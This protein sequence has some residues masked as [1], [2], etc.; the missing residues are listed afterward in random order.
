MC[1]RS[2][3]EEPS[4][5]QSCEE[6]PDR[7]EGEAVREVAMPAKGDERVAGGA[8]KDI[9]IRAFAGEQAREGGGGKG[10]AGTADGDTSGDAE[11]GVRD[12]IHALNL[13]ASVAEG[14]R[15]F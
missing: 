2:A 5:D 8:D 10:G 3:A 13:R 11:G 1:V 15:T 7:R 14:S 6:T 4:R 9:Q 12:I